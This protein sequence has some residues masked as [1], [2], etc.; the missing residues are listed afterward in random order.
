ME[1]CRTQMESLIR[2]NSTL[3]KE[4][5]ATLDKLRQ[6][7]QENVRPVWKKE[8]ISLYCFLPWYLFKK[9]EVKNSV[10]IAP[11]CYFTDF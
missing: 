5:R 10:I 6:T 11:N 3:A 7:F 2:S 8:F 1:R 4:L 9:I